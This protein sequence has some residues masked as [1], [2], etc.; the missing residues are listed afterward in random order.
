MVAATVSGADPMLRKKEGHT[1]KR[2]LDT[3]TKKGGSL[4]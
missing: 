1:S 4:W 2:G 3:Q